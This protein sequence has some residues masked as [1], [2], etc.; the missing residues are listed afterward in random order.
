M[1]MH[2]PYYG[3]IDN[4]S[5][6]NRNETLGWTTRHNVRGLQMVGRPLPPI[7]NLDSFNEFATLAKVKIKTLVMPP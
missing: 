4:E 7:S 2:V 6:S 5:S 1:P 3:Q